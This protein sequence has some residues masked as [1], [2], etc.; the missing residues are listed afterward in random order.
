MLD[1]ISLKFDIYV[2]LFHTEICLQ[3][4]NELANYGM[5]QSDEFGF[6][7]TP[8]GEGLTLLVSDK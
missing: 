1:V 8:L 7:L 3:N 6:T 2:L 5:L 4:V